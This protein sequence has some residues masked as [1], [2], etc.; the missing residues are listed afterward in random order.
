MQKPAVRMKKVTTA[1][2]PQRVTL[3]HR[4]LALLSLSL[5]MA[6]PAGASAPGV[7]DPTF[8]TDGKLITSFG[9]YQSIS[10]AVA[11]QSD[12]RIVAGGVS[13]TTINTGDFALTRYNP[14]GSLD[15]TFG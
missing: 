9:G 7:L 1:A 2:S 4:I 13:Y 3:G 10:Q 11:I 12:G 6:L 15:T 5:A 14:D 8:D